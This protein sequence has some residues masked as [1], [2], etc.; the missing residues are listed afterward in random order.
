MELNGGNIAIEVQ[1]CHDFE[2]RNSQK[3]LLGIIEINKCPMD[4]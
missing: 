3:Q 4:R 2:A 1:R